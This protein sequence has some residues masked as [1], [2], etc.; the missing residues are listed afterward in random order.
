MA[1]VQSLILILTDDR[2]LTDRARSALSA[3]GWRCARQAGLDHFLADLES[4]HPAAILLDERACDALA[5]VAAIRALPAPL[6]GT[7]VFTTG[8]EDSG[9]AGQEK[10][11][12]IAL[13]PAHLWRLLGEWA[14]P[15]DDHGLRQAPWNFRYRLIRLVGLTS[16]DAMLQRLKDTLEEAVETVA[17]GDETVP[18]HRLAGI[19]GMCGFPELGRAWSLAD[20]QEDGALDAAIKASRDTIAELDAALPAP[21]VSTD[22]ERLALRADVRVP[23]AP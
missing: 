22:G 8:H 3:H 10:H 11:I 16:A 15:L 6:N 18:A 13:P 23:Q 9:A 14:G 4:L 7:P 5:V 2:E 17:S 12:E 20:R 21:Q 1:H 19:A